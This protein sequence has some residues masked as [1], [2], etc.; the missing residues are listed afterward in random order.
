MKEK[1]KHTF[2]STSMKLKSKQKTAAIFNSKLN[3][4]NVKKFLKVK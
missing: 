3:T 4:E 2:S 1:E